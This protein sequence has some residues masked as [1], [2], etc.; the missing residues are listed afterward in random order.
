MSDMM[1]LVRKTM[2]NTFRSKRNWIFFF[3]LPILGVLLSTFIYG[4]SSGAK[5]QVGILNQDGDVSITQNAIRFVQGLN[6]VDVRMVDEKTMHDDIAS[7]KMD[8]G[9]VFEQGFAASVQQGKPEHINIVSVKGAQAT[10]YV[11]SMLQR[12]VGNVAAIGKEVQGDQAAFERIYAAYAKQSFGVKAETLEDTSRS[13]GATYQ[14]IG[15]LIA[16][17]MFSA[18]NMSELILREKENRTFL[19]LLSSPVSA[20]TFV[21]SNVIV[22]LFVMLLQIVVT[23]FLMRTVLKVDSGIPYWQMIAAL[24]L[25]ALAAIA[26]S[27]LIV[28]FAK[29]RTAANGMQNLIINPTC[30]LA[31]CYFPMSIMPDTVRQISNFVPQHWLLDMINKLQDGQGFGN[32]TLNMAILVAF[33]L[34]FALIAIFRF[35]RN[36]DTRQFI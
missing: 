23:L 20:R 4:S 22:N 27:L 14:S 15:F 3:G 2:A 28:S 30:L 26:L 32:L 8:S 21:L 10:A 1:W 19:R 11:K 25:F 33:A 36:N 17:M 16:F 13:K 18:V 12:Y 35:S 24:S 6:Q 29:S 34:A 5:L 31:G 9:I 7:G